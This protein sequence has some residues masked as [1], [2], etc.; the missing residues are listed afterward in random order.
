[1]INLKLKLYNLL[2]KFNN[3]I[4]FD[5]KLLKYFGYINTDSSP[6]TCMYCGNKKF[7]HKTIDS[8]GYTITEEKILCKNCDEMVGYWAY[9][10]YKI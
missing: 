2:I 7:Y 8:I 3:T 1:M 9:G 5:F 4:E 10:H 6:K